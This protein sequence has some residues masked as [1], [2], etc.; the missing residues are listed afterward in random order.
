MKKIAFI[1]ILVLTNTTMTFAQDKLGKAKSDLSNTSESSNTQSTSSE[2]SISDGGNS[3]VGGFVIEILYF[4]TY[5]LL[6]GVTEPRTFTGYPYEF[7]V[8]GE[9][10]YVHETIRPKKSKFIV[11]NM[12][13]SQN[14]IFGNDLRVNYRFLPI[15]GLEA[16]H[17]HLFDNTG[18]S[19]DL[20]ISSIMLNYYRIRERSVT[21]YWGMGVTYVG[22]DV[23]N[24]GFAY[25]LGLDIYMAKPV[26]LEIFWKQS[27]INESSI[28]EFRSVLRYHLKRFA[29]KGGFVNY[30]IGNENFPTGTF[31]LEFRL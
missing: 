13:V 15:L 24:S 3:F 23:N 4:A 6:I 22:S 30:K 26:S 2:G 31:G 14:D 10:D 8:N 9:Y 7:D 18:E 12:I 25:N 16:N 5:G 29:I 17:L 21:G 11:S 1:I 20:G 19:T 28:N 27:F